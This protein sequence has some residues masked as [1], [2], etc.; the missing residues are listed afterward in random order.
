MQKIF[1]T[2]LANVM[3][4]LSTN[5]VS[6]FFQPKLR[7]KELNSKYSPTVRFI[8]C[9]TLY[10]PFSSKGMEALFYLNHADLSLSQNS[11]QKALF[12]LLEKSSA[13][14]LLSNQF[15]IVIDLNLHLFLQN[16]M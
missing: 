2:S 11:F 7:R 4:N 10:L 3:D 9:P 15:M 8:Y 14:I 12:Q 1:W 13:V 6:I 16:R 5:K